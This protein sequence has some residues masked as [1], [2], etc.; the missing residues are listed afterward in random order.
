MKFAK[1]IPFAKLPR[2]FDYFDY[3]VPKN[4]EAQIKIGHIV[5]IYFRG[6]KIY[7]LIFD[8]KDNSQIEEKKIISIDAL[9]DIVLP[10]TSLRAISWASDN[11]LASPA[12]LCKLAI[13]DPAKRGLTTADFTEKKILS[14]D[15]LQAQTVVQILGNLAAEKQNFFLYDNAG[16]ETLAIFIK[17]AQK[18]LSRKKQI[19]ILAPAP[20]DINRF[21]PYFRAVFGG[22]MIVWRG[23]MSEREKW[24]KW[25]KVLSGRPAVILGTRPACFLPFKNL[26]SILIYNCTSADLKQWDQNP[27]YDS[28]RVAEKLREIHGAYLIWSDILPDLKIFKE[29]SEEKISALNQAERPPEFE[30]ADMKKEKRTAQSLSFP[31]YQMISEGL[32]NKQ[33]IILFANRKEKNSL[34]LCRDCRKIFSCSECGR[35]Y[36]VDGGEFWCYYCRTR[37]PLPLNCP[38]CRGM[39]LKTLSLGTENIIKNIKAEFPEAAVEIADKNNQA[40]R[41]FDILLA[42]DAFLKNALAPDKSNAVSRAA[43]IDYDSYFAKP[44]FNQKEMA[45]LALHRFLRF[46]KEFQLEKTLVQTSFPENAVFGRTADFYGQELAEREE[47]GYPPFC[48]LVKIICKAADKNALERESEALYRHLKDAGY[49]PLPPFEPFVKKRTKKYLK[50]IVLKENLNKNLSQLKNLVP[51]EYQ[52]DTDPIS[53]Y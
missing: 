48:K 41:G 7:G 53:I 51:D 4:L 6:R 10:E 20:E 16:A 36:R 25:T 9:T 19:L 3:S 43:M 33:K 2:R 12:L 38:D 32:K 27:R 21:A 29:L 13:P 31:L 8:L 5:A 24:S 35:P 17:I 30:I 40:P 37:A 11:Y 28:R 14:L 22:K 15:K 50:H 47:A 42:T 34:L 39:D 26:S 52:I 23:K 1:V 45:H 44:E 46:A 49:S 18:E